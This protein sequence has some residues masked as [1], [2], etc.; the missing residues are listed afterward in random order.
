M[1]GDDE[2]PLGEDT[3]PA[4]RVVVVVVGRLLSVQGWQAKGNKS[5]E[6]Q[7]QLP[8]WR[9]KLVLLLSPPTVPG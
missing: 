7:L 8:L 1:A 3:G 6:M 4:G 2:I 5:L 9:R